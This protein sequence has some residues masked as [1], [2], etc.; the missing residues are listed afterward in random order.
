M[1]LSDY[2]RKFNP[3]PDWIIDSLSQAWPMVDG[4][5]DGEELTAWADV[6]VEICHGSSEK[7]KNTGPRRLTSLYGWA[8][9]YDSR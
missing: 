9:T 3:C 7:G 1:T 2:E 8:N 4:T 6:G 5:L